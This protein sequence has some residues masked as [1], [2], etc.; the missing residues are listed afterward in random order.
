MTNGEALVVSAAM[1]PIP[2]L[3]TPL[4]SVDI[5]THDVVDASKERSDVCA[6]PAAAVVGEAEVAMVLADSYTAKFGADC[7]SDIETALGHYRARL[8][9]R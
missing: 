5:D 8:A 7:M 3:M 9:G 4:A 6:V 2:T 1:K